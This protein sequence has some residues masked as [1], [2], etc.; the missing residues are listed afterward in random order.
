MPLFNFFGVQKNRGLIQ[1]R[2]FIGVS[3]VYNF[4]LRLIFFLFL[5]LYLLFFFFFFFFFYDCTLFVVLC[6]HRLR[7]FVNLH[8]NK[9]F[10]ATN[11]KLKGINFIQIIHI[12]HF[13]FSFFFVPCTDAER[14]V[15]AL[16]WSGFG[17]WVQAADFGGD[18]RQIRILGPSRS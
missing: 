11:Y 4:H 13:I 9:Y 15:A 6:C 18:R 8:S 10:D 3:L 7:Y 5:F 1:I 16:P 14:S 12:F 17:P 2:K